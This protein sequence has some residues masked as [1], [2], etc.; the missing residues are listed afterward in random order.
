MAAKR[1]KRPKLERDRPRR[2]WSTLFG[3]GPAVKASGEPG[4]AARSRARQAG[5]ENSVLTDSVELGYRVIE[6]YLKQGQQAAQ[7]FGSSR[8]GGIPGGAPGTAD[9][10]QQLTQRV[11]QYGWDFAGL[12][13]E[14]WSRLGGTNGFP[15]PTTPFGA[16]PAPKAPPPSSASHGDAPAGPAP[17]VSV[18]VRSPQLVATSV[19]LQAGAY[20]RLEILALRSEDRDAPPIESVRIERDSEPGAWAIEVTVAAAQRPG[21]YRAPIVDAATNLPKGWLAVKVQPAKR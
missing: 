6:D 7:A 8:F 1:V 18:S 3:P 12:W 20:E 4:D 17:V 16:P 10:M 11:M 2:E 13:F 5:S 14:M 21:T 19:E 15:M 9:D